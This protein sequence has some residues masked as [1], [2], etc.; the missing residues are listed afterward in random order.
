MRYWTQFMLVIGLV[1]AACAPEAQVVPTLLPATE[2][3]TEV[4]TDAP[5][6]APIERP[7]LPPE[8]TAA[9]QATDTP[10]PTITPNVLPTVSQIQAILPTE[11][12]GCENF[13][14][15]LAR[16]KRS[17]MRGDD[18]AVFWSMIDGAE[19]YKVMLLNDQ[20]EEIFVDYVNADGYIFTADKFEPGKLYGWQVHPI[21][22]LG[23]Q[24]C[25]T[26]GAELAPDF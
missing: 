17:Y 20:A 5:T 19:F 10:I 18:V 1:L 4:P 22:P 6:A 3:P 12:P 15:D 16:T 11:I 8:W 2:A 13:G 26:Q 24:M 14:V 9:P 23:V 25:V 7:T 21:N